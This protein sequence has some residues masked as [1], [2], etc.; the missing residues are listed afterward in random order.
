MYYTFNVQGAVQTLPSKLILRFKIDKCLKI[1]RSVASVENHNK[2]PSSLKWLWEDM[3]H[4]KKID[5]KQNFRFF[6]FDE[7]NKPGS[8]EAN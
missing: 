2:P 6:F 7:E 5:R 4:I 8:N 1:Q 3:L